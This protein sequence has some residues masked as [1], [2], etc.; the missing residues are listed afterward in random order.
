MRISDADLIRERNNIFHSLS[1]KAELPFATSM[2][3]APSDDMD[4][5]YWRSNLREINSRISQCEERLSYFENNVRK[6]KEWCQKLEEAKSQYEQR[7]SA[8]CFLEIP[9]PAN[10][11]LVSVAHFAGGA[12]EGVPLRIKWPKQRQAFAELQC[13]FFWDYDDDSILFFSETVGPRQTKPFFDAILL[14][15]RKVIEI[16]KAS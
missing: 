15:K 5:F 6:Q 12:L 16:L 4:V 2:N 14:D 8:L 1:V 3:E 11:K 9:V 13:S 7:D 10:S